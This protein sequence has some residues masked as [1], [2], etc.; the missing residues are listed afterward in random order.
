M[1]L[2]FVALAFFISLVTA[3]AAIIFKYVTLDYS[4]ESNNTILIINISL[5]SLVVAGFISLI[6]LLVQGKNLHTSLKRLTSNKNRHLKYVS[7][8]ALLYILNVTLTIYLYD[9]IHNPAFGHLII[10][11]NVILILLYSLLFFKVKIST[12]GLIGFILTFV[13]LS[14]IILGK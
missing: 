11:T 13:G 8:L 14:L 3:V 4:Q 6:V 1:K 10:N 12:Q 5:M 2:N 7:I 9:R